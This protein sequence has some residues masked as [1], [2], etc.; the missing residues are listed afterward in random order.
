MSHKQH[1][2]HHVWLIWHCLNWMQFVHLEWTVRLL[3]ALVIRSSAE[4]TVCSHFNATSEDWWVSVLSTIIRKGHHELSLV[5]AKITTVLWMISK[6]ES[7]LCALCSKK[8]VQAVQSLVWLA[9]VS[10]LQ[11]ET[12]VGC[13]SHSC[14]RT[15]CH[16]F[17]IYKK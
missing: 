13:I 9:T 16:A 12:C 17:L 6:A 14:L 7:K 3:L 8:A 4:F 1:Y 5:L 10:N 11:G 15:Y 2:I